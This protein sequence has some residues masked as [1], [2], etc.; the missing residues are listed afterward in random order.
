MELT[1]LTMTAGDQ[2]ISGWVIFPPLAFL[3]SYIALRIFRNHVLGLI[4]AFAKR[5]STDLDD[6]LIDLVSN[7]PWSFYVLISAFVSFQFVEL[8]VFVTDTLRY[9]I[10]L[11]AVYYAINAIHIVL[12]FFT[13]RLVKK[14]LTADKTEDVSFIRLLAR[15]F[16][17]SLWFVGALLIVANM[18]VDISALIA[19]MGVGGLAIALAAQ[20]VLEDIFAS[21]SI[22][23]DKPYKIGDF[24]LIGDDM[25]EV[26]RIGIK[27]T[28]IKTLRG[29]ELVV[30]NKEMTDT[31]VHNFGK[32]P[33]RRIE[34]GFGVTYETP[35]EK[36]KGIPDIVR[37][38]IESQELV[39][40][41]RAHFKKFGDFSLDFEVIYFLMSAD[42]NK[43]MDTQQAVNLDLMQAFEREGIEFAYPTQKL[44]LDR[45]GG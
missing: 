34:F 39:R 37:G 6:L 43:Y 40:F 8:S 5:T 7:I 29:E 44:F 27:T 9:A 4:K 16:K 32:M 13:E 15:L 42:Y 23:F 45:E 11:I 26:I 25:G 24:I 33:H 38:I 28:R 18:G 41:D 20:K 35:A 17:Y 12:D 2:V 3:I 19:G 36:I 31:R 21:F 10:L 22:Y 30:S 1:E 14:R